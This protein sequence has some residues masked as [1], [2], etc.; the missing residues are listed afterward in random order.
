MDTPDYETATEQDLMA[1]RLTANIL[2][3][4]GETAKEITEVWAAEGKVTQPADW[5]WALLIMHALEAARLN[6]SDEC[7]AA[8][9]ADHVRKMV[10]VARSGAPL[11]TITER[12]FGRMQ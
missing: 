1:A 8:T 12:D 10:D 7:L 5:W 2:R 9:L 11:F 6:M 4:F 3:A